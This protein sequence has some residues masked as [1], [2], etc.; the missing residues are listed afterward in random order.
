MSLPRLAIVI[1]SWNTRGDVLACLASLRAAAVSLPHETWVVD[2][3]STDGTADAIA[4]RHP[5]VRLVR[6]SE[7]LGFARGNNLALAA[8][9]AE[10]VLLLNPDTLVP[11]GAVEQLVAHLE[12]HPEV[13]AVGPRLIFGDGT[14]QLSAMPFVA[15]WDLYWEHA[16]FPASLQPRAQ[17]VPRRLYA[18]PEA[19]AC[20]VDMVIGAALLVRGEVLSRVGLLDEGY[21]MYGE[22]MDWCWRIR[23]AGWGVDWL[24]GATITHL[25]GRAAAQVPLSTLAHRFGSTFRFL[26]L[27]RGPG[28]ER[29]ARLALFLAAV[30]NLGW[31]GLRTLLGRQPREAWRR[32]WT[33]ARVA[34]A[35]AWHGQAAGHGPR[36]G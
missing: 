31:G 13:G 19:G 4:E 25:G 2:N 27:H 16:R 17:R 30:Q 34:L 8:L 35:T 32:E 15:P 7:N 5:E 24:A 1:V 14:F 28:A 11:P 12:A 26:R 23:Q 18:L 21:F 33:E 22:E 9:E 10:H 3:A 36:A 20:P 29:R 6:A